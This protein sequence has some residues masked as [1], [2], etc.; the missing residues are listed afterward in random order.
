MKPELGARAGDER[1]RSRIPGGRGVFVGNVCPSSVRVDPEDGVCA[2][3]GRDDT[4][5]NTYGGTEASE[6]GR[7]REIWARETGLAE[8][9]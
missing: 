3:A 9:L 2:A 6:K 5:D 1:D 4:V 8:K 7:G